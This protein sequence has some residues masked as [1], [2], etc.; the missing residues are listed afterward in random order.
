MESRQPARVLGLELSG[1]KNARTALAVLEHYPRERKVFV[2]DIHEGIGPDWNGPPDGASGSGG[3]SD[4]ALLEVIGEAIRS[5]AA[6]SQKPSLGVNAPLSLPPCIECTRKTCPLPEK[7]TVPEVR[8][9]REVTRKGARAVARP[10][11]L[12]PFTPYTQRPVELW[13][14]YQVVPKLSE[15][16]EVD[17]AMG[18]N[19]AALAARMHFLKRHLGGLDCMEVWPKLS[20]AMIAPHLHLHRRTLGS[21]RHLENGVHAREEILEAI[22]KHRGVFIYERDLRKLALNLAAFDAF[23]CAYTAVLDAMGKT[24]KKPS[25]FPARE[26]WVHYPS[27]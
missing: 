14:K 1:A 18:G 24:V 20:V 8:W 12:K 17:E 15:P 22:V 11:R 10:H 7:C 6:L 2:L 9:M 25:G 27:T 13:L 21:Y 23:F 5:G 16:P 3:N 19:R 26:S 4:T